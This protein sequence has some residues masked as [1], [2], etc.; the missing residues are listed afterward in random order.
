[1][2]RPSWILA[3]LAAGCQGVGEERVAALERRLGETESRLA[4]ADEALLACRGALETG[5][6]EL[7]GDLAKLLA[8]VRDHASR[9]SGAGAADDLA[10]ALAQTARRVEALERGLA[11]PAVAAAAA[12]ATGVPYIVNPRTE[13]PT[14]N[15]WRNAERSDK[16]P[17]AKVTKGTRCKILETKE[18]EK[19]MGGTMYRVVADTGETGWLPHFCLEFR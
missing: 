13:A 8:L 2:R 16:L 3:V 12:A 11:R 4:K 9:L 6:K 10:R 7:R 15:L 14:V 1:M 17:L 18:L 19:W 5:T